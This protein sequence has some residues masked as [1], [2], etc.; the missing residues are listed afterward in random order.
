MPKIVKYKNKCILEDFSKWTKIEDEKPCDRQNCLVRMETYKFSGTEINIYSAI[1]LSEDDIWL[2]DM[3]CYS[4]GGP[5]TK[6]THW[7]PVKDGDK[8]ANRN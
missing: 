6:I 8:N 1:Y 7:R 4:D 2:C 5:S 3:P